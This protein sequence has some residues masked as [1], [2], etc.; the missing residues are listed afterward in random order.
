MNS[1]DT[2]LIY[3]NV[4][5]FTNT[6]LVHSG[7]GDGVDDLRA[8]PGAGSLV[9]NETGLA[10]DGDGDERSNDFFLLR[11]QSTTTMVTFQTV[12][13]RLLDSFQMKSIQFLREIKFSKKI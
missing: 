3:R 1:P 6:L 13:A 10:E 8:G 5:T 7:G 11:L 9:D 12:L 4:P 2:I